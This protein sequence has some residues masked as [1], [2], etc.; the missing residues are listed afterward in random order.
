MRVQRTLRRLRA[1]TLVELLV[2]IGIIGLLIGIMLPTLSRARAKANQIK[3]ASNLRQVGFE[4]LNYSNNYRGW[5]FPPDLGTNMTVPGNPSQTDYSRVWLTHVFK[6]LQPPNFTPAIMVCPSDQE[7][8][9]HHS[10]ILNDH[11]KYKKIKYYTKDLGGWTPS[12][13]VLMGEKVSDK[14]DYYLEVIA[15]N[16]TEFFEVVELKRHG[17][18]FGSNY[19]YLDIHVDSI[20]P[21]DAADPARSID[22]WDP[23]RTTGPS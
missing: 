17:L 6:N 10:Y 12:R 20:T 5:M 9:D 23:P 1:F 3:C 4:L 16:P 22:P 21:E 7:P 13:V 2:V 19:L 11:L 14:R 8:A 15:S 18:K